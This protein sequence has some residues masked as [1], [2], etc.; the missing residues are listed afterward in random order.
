MKILIVD[1]APFIVESFTEIF[2]DQGWNVV[3][4]AVNGKEAIEKFKI[5]KP[6]IVIMDILMPELD[7]LTAIRKIIELDKDAKIVVVSA[8]A[9]RDLDKESIEAGA[10]FFVKKPFDIDDLIE[11]IRKVYEE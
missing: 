7:G 4:S 2:Q 1:D 8:L 6:D 10:K 3:G 11:K 5:T 9:K